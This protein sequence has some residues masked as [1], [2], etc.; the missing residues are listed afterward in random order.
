M[1]GQKVKI[2]MIACYSHVSVL[3]FWHT[4]PC[5]WSMFWWHLLDFLCVIS[6]WIV[7]GSAAAVFDGNDFIFQ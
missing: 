7:F 3:M 1:L 2:F 6:T 4:L 5:F